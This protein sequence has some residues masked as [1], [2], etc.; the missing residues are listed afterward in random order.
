MIYRVAHIENGRVVNIT[1]AETLDGEIDATGARIGD[2]Y[3]GASFTPHVKTPEE[4]AADALAEATALEMKAVKMFFR[5]VK[6]LLAA[7]VLNANDPNLA[8]IKAAY[9][10]WKQLTGN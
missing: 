7:D 8:E 1:L 6:A 3:D 4:L 10:R 9:L 5:L 2:H